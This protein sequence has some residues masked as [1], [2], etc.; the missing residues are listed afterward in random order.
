MTT[1]TTQ[2]TPRTDVT[3]ART[4]AAEPIRHMTDAAGMADYLA[5]QLEGLTRLA[6]HT[7]SEIL[8]PHVTCEIQTAAEA[9]TSPAIAIQWRDAFADLVCADHAAQAHANGITVVYGRR[10]DGATT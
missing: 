8:G 1:S 5:T 7:T 6:E 3:T 10:H 2:S 4:W 9:C